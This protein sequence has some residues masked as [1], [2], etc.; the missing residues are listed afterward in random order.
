MIQPSQRFTIQICTIEKG[1]RVPG[2][3]R[4]RQAI[5]AL[6]RGYGLRIEGIQE[7]KAPKK[8]RPLPENWEA[9]LAKENSDGDSIAGTLPAVGPYA[10]S[11]ACPGLAPEITKNFLSNCPNA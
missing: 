7:I 8:E 4:L 9:V 3:V 6:L 10:G 11:K 2:F 5:K 1:W